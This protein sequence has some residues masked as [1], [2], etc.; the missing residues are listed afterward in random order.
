MCRFVYI[1]SR[2]DFFEYAGLLISVRELIFC[3]NGSDV[4]SVS[5]SETFTGVLC[6]GFRLSR[7]LDFF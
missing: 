2:T 5:G 6:A 7:T 1:S 4:S 3:C